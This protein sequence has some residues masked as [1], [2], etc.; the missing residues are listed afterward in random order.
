MIKS[1]L[2]A[3]SR[4]LSDVSKTQP[5]ELGTRDSQCG[6][7]LLEFIIVICI[8]SILMG[9]ILKRVPP[10]Q[11][12]AE[13]AAMEQTVGAL[14][15]ALT[16]RAGTLMAR[17]KANTKELNELASDNPMNWLQQKP[18]N[19]AGEFFDPTEKTVAPGDWVFDLKSH[20]LIYVLDRS[21]H[22]T[23]GNDGQK[24]IRFHV[25][26]DYEPAPGSSAGAKKELTAVVF[27]AT[28]RYRWFD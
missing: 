8:I 9:A 5:S 2:S 11:E 4:V 24:W 16:L 13:K 17:G 14:Q 12:Q 18:R 1:V 28:E 10:Y 23:P 25:R 7:T 19:Y 6:F 22:F 21:D 3:E 20:D 27:E 15:T 26:Q